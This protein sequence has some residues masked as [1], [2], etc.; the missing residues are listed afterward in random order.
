MKSS[1]FTRR[2]A[3]TAVAMVA[4]STIS[5]IEGG[6]A[7]AY[8]GYGAIAV[9]PSGAY[10]SS[11]DYPDAGSAGDAALNS[12]GYRNCK[13]LTNF[14][15]CGAVASNSSYFQGGKG[16]TLAAA[17]A[18]ALKLLGTDGIIETWACN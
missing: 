17:E 6:A 2:A 5:A 3:V 7:Q 9:N 14:T 18:N 4:A 10:G 12:C 15:G 13:V 16:P 8:V 11:W 1:N